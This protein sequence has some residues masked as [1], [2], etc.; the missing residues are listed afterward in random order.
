MISTR[1]AAAEPIR[2]RCREVT[3]EG[4]SVARVREDFAA[5]LRRC[6]D[7]GEARRCDVVLAVHEALANA[8]EFA[9]RRDRRAGTVDLEATVGDGTLT[10]TVVDHGHWRSASRTPRRRCRG[11]G[12]PLMR[13]LADGVD[14]DAA[15]SGT[16]VRLRFDDAHAARSDEGTARGR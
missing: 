14:I 4:P 7:L 10:V 2:F 11:R 8:A 16:S 1:P 6:T 15:P 5:W 12:I 13:L 3:A 9:Y